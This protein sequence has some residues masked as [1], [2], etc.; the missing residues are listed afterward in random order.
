MGIDKLNEEQKQTNI[1]RYDNL[2]K[3]LNVVKIDN[4]ATTFSNGTVI[5]ESGDANLAYWD[6]LKTDRDLNKRSLEISST[7]A[8]KMNVKNSFSEFLYGPDMY[9]NLDLTVADYNK[10][11]SVWSKNENDSDIKNA[12]PQLIILTQEL[13]FDTLSN[14][15]NLEMFLKI[16][17]IEND[18]YLE[19]IGFV[20]DNFKTKQGLQTVKTKLQDYLALKKKYRQ[21]VYGSVVGITNSKPNLKVSNILLSISDRTFEETRKEVYAEYALESDGLEKIS[22][23]NL[24]IKY[25][26]KFKIEDV[27]SNY[28]FKFNSSVVDAQYRSKVDK[29]HKRFDWAFEVDLDKAVQSTPSTS[30][31]PS[32]T[33][34]TVDTTTKQ[35]LQINASVLMPKNW[36]YLYEKNIVGVQSFFISKEQVINSSDMFKTGLTLTAIAST[37]LSASTAEE[38]AKKSISKIVSTGTETITKE[39]VNGVFKIFTV[40]KLTIDPDYNYR[41]TTKFYANTKTNIMYTATFEAPDLIWKSEWDNIGNQILQSLTFDPAK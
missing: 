6:Y 35:L 34:S 18:L 36:F 24:L 28:Y 37:S 25:F 10:L 23:I 30:T 15:S 32:N 31:I 12:V 20:T 33:S 22:T 3:F 7:V 2:I 11:K 13:G 21:G 4:E 39:E 1:K 19:N 5:T 40:S 17:S 8:Q 27:S 26:G 14:T 9:A 41:T 16:K 29:K 38:T